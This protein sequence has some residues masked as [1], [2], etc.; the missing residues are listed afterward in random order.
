M[1]YGNVNRLLKIVAIIAGG[2]SVFLGLMVIFGW[3]TATVTLIQV[4]PAFVPM[5]YNTALGF[6]LSGLGI[7]GY[8]RMRSSVAAVCGSLVAIIGLLTLAEYIFYFNLGIDELFMKHYVGVKTSHMGR[9]APNTALSFMFT[10]FAVIMISMCS[11]FKR[12]AL[13]TAILSALILGL[14]IIAFSG[15][16]TGLETAYGWGHLTQMAVHTAF[17]FMVLGLGL[18]ALSWLKEQEEVFVFPYWLPIPIAI[19]VLTFSVSLWQSLHHEIGEALAE[20]I[21]HHFLLLFGTILA[22]VLAMTVNL[23]QKTFRQKETIKKAHDE[24]EIRVRERTE[25]LANANK[26]LMAEMAERKRAE[27]ELEQKRRL[28]IMGEMSAHVAHEIRNPLNK[29]SISYEL[30]NNSGAIEGRDKEALKIMGE[31]IENLI[32]LATD[33]LDYGRGTELNRESF[34]CCPFLKSIILEFREKADK[35]GVQFITTVPE[36]CSLLNADRIKVHQLLVNILDNAIE[37]MPDGGMLTIDALEKEG[38]LVIKI[39]DTGMGIEK[40]ELENIFMPFFTTKPV[41]TG[42]GMAISRQFAELHGGDIKVIS[43]PGKGTTVTVT[44]PLGG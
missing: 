4:Y 30:L 35:A 27:K 2:A 37:A 12:C 8:L 5:Q 39:S 41:G 42:L 25:A 17:G 36:S 24:L 23:L 26:D 31:E 9:M 19:A 14:S 20:R 29:V 38:K 21:A 13:V 43:E 16:L 44:L 18:F 6:F 40:K 33:L 32:S 28:A 34:G 15:Y 22:F 1:Q 10:G 3:Y 11:T 7:L